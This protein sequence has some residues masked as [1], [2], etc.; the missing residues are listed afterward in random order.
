MLVNYIKV[1]QQANVKPI[2][3][4]AATSN[5]QTGVGGPIPR[6]SGGAGSVIMGGGCRCLATMLVLVGWWV[7]C[8][9]GLFV[10]L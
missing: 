10:D 2:E 5:N 4:Q 9:G 3:D 1:F 7:G 6:P 8:S